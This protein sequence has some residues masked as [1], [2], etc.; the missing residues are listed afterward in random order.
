MKSSANS[1]RTGNILIFED[2]LWSVIKQPE[3]IKPGK[4]PAYIQIEIKKMFGSTKTNRRLRSS[5][6]V[7]KAHLEERKHKYLYTL[8]KEVWFMDLET[9]EQTCI[10]IANAIEEKKF[11]TDDLEVSIA[12]FQGNPI[13]LILPTTV[14]LTITYTP[15]HI[16]GATATASYKKAEINPELTVLVP[17]YLESG[18]KIAVKTE[19]GSFIERVK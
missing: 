4:G 13:K 9:F 16:K 3:H 11:L 5:D 12:F 1:I 8:D 14:V 17:V 15:P 7:E 2:E 10:P 6:T 18:D 19:D